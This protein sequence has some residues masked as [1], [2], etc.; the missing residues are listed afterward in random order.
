MH[1]PEEHPGAEPAHPTQSTR[2]G[3]SDAASLLSDGRRTASPRRHA[4]RAIFAVPGSAAFF[5]AG[6]LG[7]LPRSTLSIGSVL[8][9]AGVTGSYTLAAAVA[10]A[11]VLGTAFVGPLWSRAMDRWG[12]RPV[13]AAGLVSSTLLALAFVGAVLGGLP[14]GMWFPLAFLVGGTALDVGSAT[15]ARWSALL[16]DEGRRHTAFSVESVA[17][18]SVFVIGPPVVTILAAAIDPALG[19]AVGLVF[20]I[21]GQGAL[22]ALR[23]TTPAVHPDARP[24]RAPFLRRIPSG[25][26]G[27]LPVFFGVGAVFGS[28]DLTAVAFSAEQGQP[29][30]AGIVLALFALGSVISGL[31]FGA[32]RLRAPLVLRVGVSAVVYGL[33]VPVVAFMPSLP[34]IGAVLLVAGFATTPLL[35]SG[36]A[37]VESRV[38]RSRLTEALAW[39]STALSIGVTVG[40]ALAGIVIDEV[41]AR[42]GFGITA[43]GAVFVGVCGLITL[44][45]HRLR[46]QPVT[47]LD[48]GD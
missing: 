48:Q 29:A 47:S 26:M 33:L 27:S 46:S 2:P 13:L 25:L 4:Y 6:W 21:V 36:M 42:G 9:V 3:A 38:H 32:L 45:S 23:R 30:A 40:S 14:E 7:R 44:V 15:R 31:A 18:E 19:F 5:A 1:A 16:P 24:D 39:P 20:G 28:L 17:D 34:A 8:L 37:L 41:S 35:I 43:A 22:I 12:Q 10:G 11:L